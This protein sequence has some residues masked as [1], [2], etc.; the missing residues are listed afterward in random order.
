MR[1]I[2]EAPRRPFFCRHGPSFR[3]FRPHLAMWEFASLG[4]FSCPSGS[5]PLSFQI[6]FYVCLSVSFIVRFFCRSQP[7]VVR[8]PVKHFVPIL[9]REMRNLK[10]REI[11]ETDNKIK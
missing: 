3:Q 6:P 2:A 8:V 9:E 1:P 4:S 5:T 11:M 7:F 10:F